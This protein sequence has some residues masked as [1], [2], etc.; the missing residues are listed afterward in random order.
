MKTPQQTLHKV[1]RGIEF[2][3]RL[4]PSVI[5]TIKDIVPMTGSIPTAYRRLRSLEA[6]GLATIYR[7]KF[8]LNRAVTQP[9]YVL[10]KLIPSLVALKNSKKFGRKYHIS[11]INFLKNNLPK[12]AFVTL[13]FRAW[14]LT[15]YQTPSDLYVYVDDIEK[16]AR[17][18]S[19]NGFSEGKKGHIILLQKQLQTKD[20]VEQIYFDCIAKGG[21]S[22]LDAIAIEIKYGDQLKTKAKFQLDDILKVQSDMKVHEHADQ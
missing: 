10:E 15:E 17:F 8:Q 2:A 11:D 4:E 18:L 22:I 16:S 3:S 20:T 12:N 7:S 6:L 13:D 9:M 5:H 19:D 1:E 14:D 21:R